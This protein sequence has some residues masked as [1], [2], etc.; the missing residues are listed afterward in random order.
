LT[1][2]DQLEK[3]AEEKAN[4]SRA[5]RAARTRKR[6][7]ASK[8]ITEERIIKKQASIKRTKT[9]VV[10]RFKRKMTNSIT[11][12]KLVVSK[13]ADT[14]QAL[15]RA[16]LSKNKSEMEKQE[17]LL[18]MFIKKETKITKW[19]V[20]YKASWSTSSREQKVIVRI[21]RKATRDLQKAKKKVV[22]ES[23]KIRDAKIIAVK[24]IKKKLVKIVKKKISEKAHKTFVRYRKAEK[25]LLLMISKG[26]SIRVI[27]KY[28]KRLVKA[29]KYAIVMR[30]KADVI[31]RSG[32]KA[33]R[34]GKKQEMDKPITS[35]EFK[36]KV[37][38]GMTFYEA[39]IQMKV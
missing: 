13:I 8:V 29:K 10:K 21:I 16:K 5:V 35:D 23:V 32:H 31:V 36:A 28:Q 6:E 12:Q 7:A 3:F 38:G 24:T 14:K 34:L 15:A 1:D 17:G 25:K 4:R 39:K 20:R 37:I 33:Q 26:K 27:K 9:I 22:K 19:V 30:R 11:K 2:K 18:T